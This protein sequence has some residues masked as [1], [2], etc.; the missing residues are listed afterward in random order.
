MRSLRDVPPIYR[1]ASLLNGGISVLF[2]G[3]AF[4]MVQRAVHAPENQAWASAVGGAITAVTAAMGVFFGLLAWG[5]LSDPKSRLGAWVQEFP[6]ADGVYQMA[7][8]AFVWGG[9][10]LVM[11][12]GS[13]DI[14]VGVAAL[15]CWVLLLIWIFRRAIKRDV[16]A[17][18]D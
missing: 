12:A 15:F 8:E 4:G 5:A 14:F 1:V 6:L 18:D 10:F 13:Y 17:L 2:F 3:V 16:E 7:M 11:L 9:I